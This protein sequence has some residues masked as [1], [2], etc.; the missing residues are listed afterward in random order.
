MDKPL[1][2]NRTIGKSGSTVKRIS[3]TL[4]RDLNNHIQAEAF[5]SQIYLAMAMWCE[6]CGYMG[7]AVRFRKYAEEELVHMKKLYQYILDRD[8]L[9]ITPAIPQPQNTYRDILDVIETSYK[10]EIEISES[11]NKTAALALK[12]QDFT[13]F[14]L[15][16]WFIHE[17]IEEEAKF[18]NLID[19]YNIL[20][21]TGISGIAL[22]EF[23]EILGE[24]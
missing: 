3:D 4:E 9:P 5:S 6:D 7:G 15:A 8:C 11:Y 2:I 23:D 20:M 19:Q 13:I 17:Q 18:N 21:K 16:Q 22:M 10:H 1:T 14:E 24:I 12:E